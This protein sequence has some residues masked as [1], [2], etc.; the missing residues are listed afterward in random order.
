MLDYSN[1]GTLKPIVTDTVDRMMKFYLRNVLCYRSVGG[2]WLSTLDNYGVDS[3]FLAN[4]DT[5]TRLVR[6]KSTIHAWRSVV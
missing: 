4:Y 2:L 3:L 1:T 5:D 6:I